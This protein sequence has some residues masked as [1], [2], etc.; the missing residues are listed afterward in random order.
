M[1]S[2]NRYVCIHIWLD[3]TSRIEKTFNNVC[4]YYQV[5]FVNAI[6]TIKG[7]THVEY[8]TNQITN[9][10][11]G[12]VNKKNKNADVKTHNVKNHLWIFVNA[13]IDNP[14]FESPT[15]ETLILP[16]SSFG[17]KCQLSEYFL[18]KGMVIGELV[19]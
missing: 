11:V 5:S 2:F 16:P 18:K 7:G 1:D 3:F 15:N 9:Y 4:F 17:S 12:I 6:A 19:G 10:V 8:V 14:D 13:R